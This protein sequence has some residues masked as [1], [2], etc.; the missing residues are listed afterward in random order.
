[1]SNQ[2]LKNIVQE[3]VISLLEQVSYQPGQV[4][5]KTLVQNDSVSVTLFA[6]DQGEEISS[7]ASDGDAMVTI[8][9]GL[10]KIT[11]NGTIYQLKTGET[12]VMPAT[13]P[14]ALFALEPFKMILTVIF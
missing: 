8:L 11:I 14:H 10:A 1:M 6:F 13:L 5:S 7:H 12:I 4:V 9:D 2:K 3:E